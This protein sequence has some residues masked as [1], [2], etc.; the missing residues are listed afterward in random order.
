MR[1]IKKNVWGN[2]NGYEGR[3]KV[4]EFGMDE[5]D[6]REWMNNVIDSPTEA[7]ARYQKRHPLRSRRNKMYLFAKYRVQGKGPRTDAWKGLP[8]CTQQ[9]FY[10]W[11]NTQLPLAKKMHKKYIESGKQHRYQMSLNRKDNNHGYVVGNMELIT[12]SKNGRMGGKNTQKMYR[13]QTKGANQHENQTRAR[14]Q[15][16]TA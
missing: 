12:V 4:R 6:A 3:N 5:H 13:S 2:W 10:A 14:V 15:S 16:E 11:F 8:I 9:E 1:K 7:Q